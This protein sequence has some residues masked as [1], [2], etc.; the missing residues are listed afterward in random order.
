M[1]GPNRRELATPVN[2]PALVARGARLLKS[3]GGPFALIGGAAMQAY[4]LERYTKDVDFA[5]REAQ[6][7][8]ALAAWPGESRPLRI[9]GVSLRTE[10]SAIDLVDR[11]VELRR[12]FEEAIDAAAKEG[13]VVRAEDEDVPV[14]PLEYLV[15]LKLAAPRPMDEADLAYLLEQASLDYRKARDIVHRHLGILGTRF[16]DRLARLAGRTDVRSDYDE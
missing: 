6:G 14:V 13:F 15:A 4:G 5:V 3:V 2:L 16:L 10:E 7:A 11:R 12:L 1:T 9:G 8:R